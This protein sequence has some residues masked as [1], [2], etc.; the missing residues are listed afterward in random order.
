MVTTYCYYYFLFTMLGGPTSQHDT[1]ELHGFEDAQD[2]KTG[3]NKKQT[4]NAKNSKY[5]NRIQ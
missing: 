5:L 3:G 4:K 2:E 1:I